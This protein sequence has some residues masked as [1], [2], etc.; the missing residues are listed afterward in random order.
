MADIDGANLTGGMIALRPVNPESLVVEGG[1]PAELLHVTLGYVA[2]D[3]SQMEPAVIEACNRAA[4]QVAQAFGPIEGVVAGIGIL[5]EQR[6]V[7]LLLNGSVFSE[8]HEAIW[9]ELNE[10]GEDAFPPQHLPFIPH[11]TL[12]YEIEASAGEPFFGQTI[13]FDRITL[14]IGDT[15]KEFPLSGEPV[16]A[17]IEDEVLEEISVQGMGRFA[18]V[19]AISDILSVDDG[20]SR[21]MD[22]GSLKFDGNPVILTW[23]PTS[24]GSGHE[25][26]IPIGAI[27]Q[28]EW[29][30]SE[31]TVEGFFDSSEP[32]QELRRQSLEG[33]P[34]GMSV[35]ASN[36][37]YHI[38]IRPDGGSTETLKDGLLTGALV[39][40]DAALHGTWL[41]AIPDVPIE[42]PLIAG[43]YPV[44]PPKNCFERPELDTIT[45]VT[46]DG[47]RVYGHMAGPGCHRG[48]PNQCIR[49]N[50]LSKD[51]REFNL[52][53]IPLEDGSLS[54]PVGQITLAGGHADLRLSASAA[55]A[56]YDDTNSAVA[57]VTAEWDER[58]GSILF[59]G[60]L[61]PNAT[62][63]QVRTLLA[64]GVSVDYRNFGG[65]L[66]LIAACSVNTPGF[67]IPRPMEVMVASGVQE[68]IFIP[69]VVPE[70]AMVASLWKEFEVDEMWEDWRDLSAMLIDIPVVEITPSLRKRLT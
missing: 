8:I 66:K 22:R 46:V 1:D 63:E 11:V 39:T 54:P 2:E 62:P 55:R 18:G 43:V 33:L 37:T 65:E 29:N 40:K 52:G 17:A 21:R 16:V 27:D 10:V 25:Q 30:G 20:F 26:G 60:A 50:D 53:V 31:F 49:I 32:A 57:D 38:E 67:P 28:A 7:V 59:Y 3:A 58:N 44:A 42:L 69:P 24:E 19:A 35:E 61:R 14:D 13:T 48:F 34:W 51:Y 4:A 9:D 56:H 45:P 5:G 64:S 68:A 36:G 70:D 12:G 6:A 23:W 47:P 15:Q 41:K